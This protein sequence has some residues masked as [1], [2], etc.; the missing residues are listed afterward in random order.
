MKVL[1]DTSVLVAAHLPT[2][3]HYRDASAWLACALR[4]GCELV[5]WAHSLA[6]VY[7]V[8]TRL[9]ATPPITPAA[10]WQFLENNVLSCA[11]VVALTREHYR[12]LVQQTAQSGLAGGMVYDA[13]ISKA[14]E[15][16]GTD[17]LLTFNVSHFQRVWQAGA[18][19]VASP[20]TLV[21]PGP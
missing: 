7:A 11:A 14:A 17:H 20:Q 21:P 4:G 9:P 18:A 2:H 6:E 12:E 13:I 15:V 5:V 10:A 16:A 19:R 3:P 1:F 8:L